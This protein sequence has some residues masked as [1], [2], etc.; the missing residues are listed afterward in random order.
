MRAHLQT[1]NNAGFD[2]NL[3]WLLRN[4]NA[5]A[6]GRAVFEAPEIFRGPHRFEPFG[7]RQGIAVITA[8][9]DAV[10]SSRGFPRELGPARS[11]FV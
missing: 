11:R 8:A 6:T 4:T 9:G 1:W 3:D 7:E 10:A 2:F 5:V